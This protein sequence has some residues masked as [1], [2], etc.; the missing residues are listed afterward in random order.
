[1]KGRGGDDGAKTFFVQNMIWETARNRIFLSLALPN[2]SLPS[3]FF[4]PMA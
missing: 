2:L 1:M 4:A 3:F